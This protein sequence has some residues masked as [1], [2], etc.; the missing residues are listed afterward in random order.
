MTE[1]RT[2]TDALA[3][4]PVAP[5]AP[6]DPVLN[7][8][9]NAP[10]EPPAPLDPVQNRALDEVRGWLARFITPMRETDLDLLTLW[11]AHTHL[12]TETYTT[13]RLVLDSPTHG[14]GKTTVLEH[15]QRLCVDPVQ[16]AQ[17]SSPALL[18][19]MLDAGMRTVL[20]DEADR[21]LNPKNDGVAEL[22]AVLNSGYKRGGTRPVLVPNGDGGWVSKEMPTFSP[23]A[24]AGN[25]P[26]LPDDTR[27]RCVRVLLMPDAQG[28]SEES[29]WEY[30]EDDARLLGDRLAA[31]AD[32]VREIVKA[33]RAT[34]PDGV[35]GR[36]KERWK[37]LKRVANA[38]GGDWPAVV[39][40]LAVEDLAYAQM[41][42]E[43]GL[44]QEKPTIVLLRHIAEVWAHGE[45]YIGTNDLLARLIAHD[46]DL[47]GENQM[48][49]RRALTAQRMGRMLHNGYGISSTRTERNGPRGYPLGK[50]LI[51]LRRLG[52]D[53]PN[54]TGSTG[55]DGATG[56]PQAPNRTGTSGASGET[57]SGTSDKKEPEA[58][59]AVVNTPGRSPDQ[60]LASGEAV[61]DA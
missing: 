59:T 7:G 29:D 16:A 23:V 32:E 31:W 46:Q 57:D 2:S 45:T 34:L 19:R 15:L 50:F 28:L 1:A 20:I 52:I 56:T 21:S 51:P 5:S 24:M 26:Q 11:A 41:E 30:I 54:Q 40:A 58:R 33:D 3:A 6:V 27:S 17:L 53:P 37:P 10:V 43:E 47:W 18:T 22:L 61:A 8:D 25:S 44:V 36:A 60:W 39:D 14:S 42:L 13:P 35:K 49:A 12:V 48:H 38:A 9:P 4:M 55:A